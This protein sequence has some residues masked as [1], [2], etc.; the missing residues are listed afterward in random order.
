[1]AH[2]SII[3]QAVALRDAA[4]AELSV[5]PAFV[6]FQALEDAVNRMQASA[7]PES[8][9]AVLLRRAAGIGESVASGTARRR[10]SQA[11]GAL[12]ILRERGKPMT[13]A[14]IVR[15]LPT[16]GATVGGVSPEINVSSSLSRDNRL[17]N[18]RVDGR[19]VWWLSDTPLPGNDPETIA[20]TFA[21]EPSDSSNQKGGE[22]HSPSAT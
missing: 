4:Y 6:R 1:M 2:D 13:T 5:T 21:S 16:V 7:P 22:G 12:A 10:L 14:E 18:L 8:R 11:E 15:A 9:A 17:H 19:S 3:Q 20:S